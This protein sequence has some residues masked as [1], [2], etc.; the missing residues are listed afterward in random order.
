M[1]QAMTKLR[2]G[3]ARFR[4]WRRRRPFWGGALL[5]AAGI[6]LLAAPA[7][8]SLILPIDLIIYAGVAGISGHLIGV[9]LIGIG[10]LSWFQP[11]QNSFFGMVGIMLAL[12]SFVTSNFGGF[13]IGM[14]LGIVGGGLVFAWGPEA[15]KQ[16][17]ERRHRGKRA[18]G[19]DGA[20][21]GEEARP[22]EGTGPD[23]DDLSGGD[24]N[25]GTRTG[26]APPADEGERSP[27]RARPAGTRRRT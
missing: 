18:D 20:G 23:G 4:H 2:A 24:E 11:A 1:S 26:K 3:R 25:P 15:R 7:A 21:P 12:V 16:R 27:K 22:G 14:L 9:L 10:A 6:E 8:Q 17:T 5:A 13:V 19:S